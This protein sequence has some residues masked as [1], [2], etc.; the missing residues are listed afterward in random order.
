MPPF[1]PRNSLEAALVAAAHDPDTRADFQRLLL[2]SDLYVAT[3]GAPAQ[4]GERTLKLG[5]ALQVLNVAGQ[6]GARIPALFTHECRLAAVFGEGASYVLLPAATVLEMIA[7]DGAILN[8]GQAYGVLWSRDE[9]LAMLGR[10][11]S[12]TVE[13][14]TRI[15]LGVPEK[16]PEAL[17]QRIEQAVTGEAAIKE[18]WLALAHW[19]E[20]GQS[21][22]LLDIRSTVDRDTVAAVLNDT[23]RAGPFDGLAIDLVI[24]PP[25]DKPGIGI[26]IKPEKLL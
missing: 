8:P 7:E 25:S 19:P 24:N 16:R 1:E 13:K 23:L 12:W 4:S 14:D 5:E 9:I 26:R 10:P 20:D 6:D 17:L 11:V 3:P 18:A 2:A 15:L 22:W 21:S